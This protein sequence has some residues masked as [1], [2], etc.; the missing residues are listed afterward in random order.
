MESDAEA[1]VA[2]APEDDATAS[3][4]EAAGARSICNATVTWIDEQKEL[5]GLEIEKGEV[6]KVNLKSFSDLWPV[7][8]QVGDRIS[9]PPPPGSSRFIIP[10]LNSLG[11]ASL[12]R[13][14]HFLDAMHESYE[15]EG[16][17]ILMRVDMYCFPH[18]GHLLATKLPAGVP[19]EKLSKHGVL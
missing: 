15:E 14:L 1:D 12:Q 3:P 16:A 9:F 6:R 4:P 18:V 2:A 17:Q 5:V 7:L 10:T 13:A 11:S 19:S 8:P